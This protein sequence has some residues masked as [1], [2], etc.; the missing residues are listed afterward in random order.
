MLFFPT[1]ERT[2]ELIRLQAG[3]WDSTGFSEQNENPPK[4]R[5]VTDS[6]PD[7]IIL[8][9]YL[10]K[11]Q[12]SIL[13]AGLGLGLSALP[14]LAPHSFA[15]EYDAKKPVSLQGPITKVEWMNP[16]IWV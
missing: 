5:W 1:L 2:P 12:L 3:F 6:V 13:A 7:S 11:V 4:G 9:R 8:W 10:M 15:A 14:I 16:H